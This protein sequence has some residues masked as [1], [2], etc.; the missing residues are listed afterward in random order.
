MTIE[1][2]AYGNRGVTLA[3]LVEHGVQF[4]VCNKATQ[5]VAGMLARS[6]QNSAE[7]IYQELISNNIPNSRFVPAG[8]LAA[9]RSQEYGYS[10]L[11]AG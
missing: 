5:A 7:A 8:V 3:A 4:A 6:G 9:T 1:Q 2:A 11:Y 10:F